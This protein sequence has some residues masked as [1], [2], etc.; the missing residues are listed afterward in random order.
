L[1]YND[2]WSMLH[3]CT[4]CKIG[5]DTPMVATRIRIIDHFRN[6]I[7][8]FNNVTTQLYEQFFLNVDNKNKKHRNSG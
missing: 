5:L 6:N 7:C 1:N 4:P 8:L 2:L 3:C